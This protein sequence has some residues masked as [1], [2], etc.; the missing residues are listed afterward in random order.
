[1]PLILFFKQ[2]PQVILMGLEVLET[3]IHCN[4]LF[5]NHAHNNPTTYT[6]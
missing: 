1:M 2:G 3:V 5:W 4:I 6:Q